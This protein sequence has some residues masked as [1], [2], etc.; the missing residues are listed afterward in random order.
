M[1][2]AL[3]SNSGLLL[4]SN[5]RNHLR[6]MESNVCVAPAMYERIGA[7]AICGVADDHVGVF[8]D[9]SR[10]AVLRLMSSMEMNP[11]NMNLMVKCDDIFELANS[12]SSPCMQA[13]KVLMQDPAVLEAVNNLDLFN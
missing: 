9:P 13:A 10:V 6:Q 8:F 2:Q 3:F 12:V 7:S 1:K 5:S 11:E 4:A